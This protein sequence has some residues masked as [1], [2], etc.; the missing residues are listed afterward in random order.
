MAQI[1]LVEKS[2]PSVVLRAELSSSIT[3][4][5]FYLVESRWR[6]YKDSKRPG[7]YRH[8]N[9][10]DNHN[11]NWDHKAKVN[12]RTCGHF[13]IKYRGTI[14]GLLMYSLEPRPSWKIPGPPYV[15]YIE[16]VESA[17]WNLSYY[18]GDEALFAGVG[19]SLVSAARDE[20][21]KRGYGGR[22]GLHSLKDSEGFYERIGFKNM[23]PDP[24]EGL[25][26]FE[27]GDVI[28][29]R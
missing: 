5:E 11:W 1:R 27:I 24:A 26:F 29:S 15:M 25:N 16:Y 9:L 8:E 13:A 14:Q 12:A 23:G 21:E 4:E 28:Y 18:A 6:A 20:S 19:E 3:P 7:W 22:L 10:P 17:P 2:A